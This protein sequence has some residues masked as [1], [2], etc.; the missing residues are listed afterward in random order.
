MPSR[1]YRLIWSIG[2]LGKTIRER[3]IDSLYEYG[4]NDIDFVINN[5]EIGIQIVKSNIYLW[6][7]TDKI[8][9]SDFDGTVTRSDV[10]VQIGVYFGID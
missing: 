3:I 4:R 1:V 5:N 10:I 8:V 7:Y 6:N 9:I 2:R